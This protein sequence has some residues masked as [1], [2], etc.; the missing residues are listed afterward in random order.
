MAKHCPVAMG[1]VFP[2]G[3]K[4]RQKNWQTKSFRVLIESACP[5]VCPGCLTPYFNQEGGC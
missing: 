2:V 4:K 3:S 1:P 5:S